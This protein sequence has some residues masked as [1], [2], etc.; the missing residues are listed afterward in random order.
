M[1][2]SV[3]L[4]ASRSNDIRSAESSDTDLVSSET[5][6]QSAIINTGN[7]TD[8]AYEMLHVVFEGNPDKKVLKKLIS[9]MMAKQ[10]IEENY[11]NLNRCGSVFLSMKNS[12]AIGVTEMQILKHMYQ[13]GDAT[14][15][16]PN[17]AA[18]S[19][20]LVEQSN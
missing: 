18:I 11:E 12:S 7:S 19:A 14:Q 20:V 9:V 1:C 17:Q 5:V 10:N 8:E 2:T 13:V 15:T 6:D 16:F 4:S 3:L